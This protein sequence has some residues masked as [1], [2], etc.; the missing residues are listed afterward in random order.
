MNDTEN[1]IADIT[2]SMFPM[3]VN[4]EIRCCNCIYCE[5]KVVNGTCKALPPYFQNDLLDGFIRWPKVNPKT[6]WCGMFKPR[7]EKPEDEQKKPEAKSDDD[8]EVKRLKYALKRIND[9][10]VK[11]GN[12]IGMSLTVFELKAIAETAL[13]IEDKGDGGN[14]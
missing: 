14:G 12:T 2:Q 9:S 1:K 4:S 6:D 10:I 13:G 11:S 5:D 7:H 8:G 3:T